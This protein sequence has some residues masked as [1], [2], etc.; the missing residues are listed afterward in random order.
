MTM[1]ER[2][3]ALRRIAETCRFWLLDFWGPDWDWPRRRLLFKHYLA[4]FRNPDIP[5]EY[6]PEPGYAAAAAEQLAFTDAFRRKIEAVQRST[7]KRQGVH[8]TYRPLGK[9]LRLLGTAIREGT[10]R[11]RRVFIEPDGPPTERRALERRGHN[12]S[13]WLWVRTGPGEPSRDAAHAWNELFHNPP[14]TPEATGPVDP[15]QVPRLSAG[16]GPFSPSY[17]EL[18]LK[19]AVATR[20]VFSPVEPLM[21]RIERLKQEAGWPADRPV[22]GIHVRRGDAASATEE[23]DEAPVLSTRKSFPLGTYMKAADQ[24]CERYGVRDIFL[25]TES[26]TEI[27]R[28]TKL[29][30][31]YR[32]LWIDYDRSIF[33]DITKSSQFI[34][35]LALENPDRARS[36]AETAILDLYF[37]CECD[38]FIGAFNSEF[39]VLAWLLAMGSRGHAIPY[40]SLSR[41]AGRR[42]LNP[43]N[44]LLNLRNN[45]PLE[46][47]HW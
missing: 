9:N 35:D 4:Y 34:E 10:D 42:S 16:A 15:V 8:L 11:G 40:I 5:P 14:A 38:A 26:R 17:L 31:Q 24:I 22:L 7:A 39:S 23:E 45:C 18:V 32:F 30:P 47:Y 41:A 46:L 33:P 21:A 1:L 20:Y 36:L 27:E 19:L 12:W 29:R 28:A 6:L 43:F 2:D 44:A 37:F 3:G 13:P 25:A